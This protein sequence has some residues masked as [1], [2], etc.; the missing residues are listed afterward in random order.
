MVDDDPFNVEGLKALLSLQRPAKV[1]CAF[2]GQQALDLLA[3][4]G[5]RVDLVITDFQMPVMTGGRLA[6]ELRQL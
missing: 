4:L 1:L 5:Y 3:G 6:L 2:D